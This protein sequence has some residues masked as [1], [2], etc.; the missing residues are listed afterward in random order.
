MKLHL[1]PHAQEVLRALLLYII[2]TFWHGMGIFILAIFA[3]SIFPP[4]TN[5]QKKRNVLFEGST[6]QTCA[7]C[8]I[9]LF[10]PTKK[11]L[12]VVYIFPLHAVHV[13]PF[14]QHST[15]ILVVFFM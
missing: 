1:F 14:I 3:V 12:S 2:T 13:A 9:N 4:K 15:L 7:V 6:K 8:L 10:T 5:Q 11:R